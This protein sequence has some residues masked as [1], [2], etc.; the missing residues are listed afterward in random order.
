MTAIK[1]NNLNVERGGKAV[2]HGISFAIEKGEVFA[3]LGGNGAGKSTA[4]LTLL[5]FIPITSGTATVLSL[6]H[7]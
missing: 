5:G 1:V 7:I 6:I 4:L 3:L 2:L